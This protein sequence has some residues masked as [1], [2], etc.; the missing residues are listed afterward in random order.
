[1]TNHQPGSAAAAAHPLPNHFLCLCSSQA[2]KVFLKRA[3]KSIQQQPQL[4]ARATVQHT[5]P[6]AFQF[7]AHTTEPD[8]NT[9]DIA[10]FGGCAASDNGP[11]G[12]YATYSLNFARV[13]LLQHFFDHWDYPPLV[14]AVGISTENGIVPIADDEYALYRSACMDAGQWNEAG[15]CDHNAKI[16]W[17]ALCEYVQCILGGGKCEH[18]PLCG[19]GSLNLREHLQFKREAKHKGW[20]FMFRFHGTWSH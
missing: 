10:T 1:M 13:Y 2:E 14:R 16:A 20:G 11:D 5:P 7:D 17:N 9:I 19:P 18:H 15:C 12:T 6:N 3:W 4:G 8:L